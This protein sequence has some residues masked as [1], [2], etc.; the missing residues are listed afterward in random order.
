MTSWWI[1]ATRE[2]LRRLLDAREVDH[3]FAARRV[4]RR[5][6]PCGE[7][8]IGGVTV[9]LERHQPRAGVRLL[10]LA[11]SRHA[12]S[13]LHALAPDVSLRRQPSPKVADA[14]ADRGQG[15]S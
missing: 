8:L 3:E 10:L 11:P 7:E 2:W 13:A 1:H 4:V 12:Q 14:Q 6:G 15:V 9:H 5:N